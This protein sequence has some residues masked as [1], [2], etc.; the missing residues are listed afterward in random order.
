MRVSVLIPLVLGIVALVAF[1]FWYRRAIARMS[2][3]SDDRAPAAVRLTSERLSSLSSPGWRVVHEVP[4]DRLGGVDHVVIGPPGV[5]AIETVLSDR[6]TAVDGGRT[7][8]PEAT[9]AAATARGAVDD[10]THP[11]GIDCRT[12]AKAFWGAPDADRPAADE[13][14]P[15]VVDVEGQRLIDWLES[16]PPS[17]MHSSQV[18]LVW[19]AVLRGIGRP[20]PLG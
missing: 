7:L 6:P 11:V 17:T 8:T 5:I 20:D 18:D 9:M 19:S 12:L 10:L 14:A 4:A 16:L 15:G 13:V 1:W 3:D 2:P